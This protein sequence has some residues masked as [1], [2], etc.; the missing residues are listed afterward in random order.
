MILRFVTEGHASLD[1]EL[2][3]AQAE[4]M[5]GLYDALRS[6]S[7]DVTA[8]AVVLRRSSER[9]EAALAASEGDD[10]A[11]LNMLRR[12][13]LQADAFAGARTEVFLVSGVGQALRVTP[14][15]IFEA[16]LGD[17]ARSV[18]AETVRWGQAL[19]AL[20]PPLPASLQVLTDFANDDDPGLIPGPRA[21][22]PIVDIA[23]TAEEVATVVESDDIGS[24]LDVEETRPVVATV[25]EKVKRKRKSAS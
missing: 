12:Q 17:L 7:I 19:Q 2:Y 4:S 13:I 15:M 21:A 9:C 16:G 1:Y 10:D 6:A 3:G 23:I 5:T 14:F 25:P 22:P 20:H 8:D 24:L 11:R 18:A